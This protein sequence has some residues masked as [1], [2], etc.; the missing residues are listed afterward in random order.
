M[1]NFMNLENL[2]KI[3]LTIAIPTYNRASI[4]DGNLLSIYRQIENKSLPIEIIISDNCSP[5][6]TTEVVKKYISKGMSITYIK[7]ENNIGMDGNF[8][9]CYRMAKGKYVLVLGDDDYLIEGKLEVLLNYLKKGDYGL[10]HLKTNSKS[11]IQEE[12]YTDNKAFLKNV[13]YWITYITSNIVNTKYI[14]GFDF[15]KY[16]GTYLTIMP[17]YLTASTKH[18]HNLMIHERIFANGLASGKN[19]GYNFF[20]VF[21]VNYLRLWKSFVSD[22]AISRNLYQWIKHDVLKNHL[23]PYSYLLLIKRVKNNYQLKG[24][25]ISILKYYSY[26]PYFYYDYV[27]CLFKHFVYSLKKVKFFVRF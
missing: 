15:E 26:C 6:N 20:D 16:F 24:A 8:A 7:N 12:V 11:I 27:T 21:L 10:V 9:Q 17:L 1:N 3:L 18:A 23:I 25:W 4:L 5:D 13:S 19:G 14:E 2:N 22:G